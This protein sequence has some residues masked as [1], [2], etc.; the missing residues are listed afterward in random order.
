MQLHYP[1]KTP[2][3]FLQAENT[4]HLN[5]LALFLSL[6]RSASLMED[7]SGMAFIHKSSKFVQY[8]TNGPHISLVN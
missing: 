6:N 7:K 5:A 1:T 4:I 3:T 8:F 2:P